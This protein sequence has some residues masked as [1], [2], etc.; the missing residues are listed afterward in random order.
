[1]VMAVWAVLV[2]VGGLLTLYLSG[3]E[4]HAV[5]PGRGAPSETPSSTYDDPPCPSPTEDDATLSAC[6]HEVGD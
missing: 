6:A 3:G 4:G 5:D 1:M 2:V